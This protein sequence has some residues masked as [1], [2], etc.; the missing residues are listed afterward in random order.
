MTDRWRCFVAVPIGD[1]LRT[2]LAP[3]VAK[4]RDDPQLAGLRWSDPDAWHVTLA[5]LGWTGPAEVE[6]IVSALRAVAEGSA[7]TSVPTGGIGA[8]PSPG[9]ARVLWYRVED[10][11]N[12]L[13][14]LAGGL[15]QGLQFDPP[16]VFRAH[17]TLA[18]ARRD[19]VNLRHAMDGLVAPTGTLAVEE[20]RLMRSHLG[21]GPPRYETLES[22]RL[23]APLRV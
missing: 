11:V 7:P 16:P 6:R 15:H 4:W 13:A 22:V 23:G 18:R 14:S 8:F 9:R 20:I 17:L 2:E 12:A 19:P 1:R 21:G 5:F 3:A 10:P